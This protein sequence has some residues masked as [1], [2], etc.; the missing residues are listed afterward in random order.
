MKSTTVEDWLVQVGKNTIKT[1]QILYYNQTTNP[2]REI[3]A[4]F[5]T[6]CEQKKIPNPLVQ[7]K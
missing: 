6:S 3:K 7:I 5:E 1:T 4:T 2:K